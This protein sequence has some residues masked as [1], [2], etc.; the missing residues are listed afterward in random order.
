MA[1]RLVIFDFDGTLADSLGWFLDIF[2]SMADRYGFRRLERSDLERLRGLDARQLLK[3]HQVPTWKLP[4][5][6]GH[7]RKLQS[8][9]LHKISLFPD[10]VETVL[11]LSTHGVK[12]AIVTSNARGN[13]ESVLGEALAS[14]I[15][16]Y[17]CGSSLFGKA[18]KFRAVA[19]ALGI[20]PSEV[21][22]IGDEIRDIEAA[23]AAGFA[24]GAVTWGYA[25]REG[26]ERLEPQHIFDCPDDIVHLFA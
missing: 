12:I 5:M 17:A 13:V 6:A 20:A 3:L 25:T 14:R 11:H 24:A 18:A 1:Y 15:D 9:E 10:I 8:Q 22:A 4:M 26:L 23:R 21:L 19:K 16:H 7:V 2:D